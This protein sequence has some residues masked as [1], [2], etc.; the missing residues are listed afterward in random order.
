[1]RLNVAY[2]SSC[3]SSARSSVFQ[4]IGEATLLGGGGDLLRAALGAR[5][6]DPVV[7]IPVSLI[8]GFALMYAFGFTITR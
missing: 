3:S 4:T 6:A 2:D 5:D 7:T 8:G 1:M